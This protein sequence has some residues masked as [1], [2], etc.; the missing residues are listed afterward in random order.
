MGA[1]RVSIVVRDMV[2]SFWNGADRSTAGLA[3]KL[4]SL[5][6]VDNH[7]SY[8]HYISILETMTLM[9]R[10]EELRVF[11]AV[12][13]GRSFA[14][15]ARRL[16]ISPAQASKL[17]A[18]LEDRLGT[19]LLNRTTRDVS[20]TDNGR[21][22]LERGRG[23]MEEFDQMEKSV[24]ETTAPRGS[25]KVTA[26]V[27]FGMQQL[28]P[29]LLDF[30]TA[31][32]EV[33]LEVSFA[34]RIVNLVDDGF[35]VAI[36]IGVL[37]DS[38]LVARKLAEVRAITF[39]SPSYIAVHGR[40]RDPSELAN[41]ETILDINIKDPFVWAFGTGKKRIDVKVNGRLRFSHPFVCLA[42]ARAGLGIAR[43]PA[44]VATEDLRSGR[45]EALLREF[46]PD[47]VAIHAVYPH[48]RHLASK[49]R[50]FV[51]FMAKRFAGEPEWHQGWE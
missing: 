9:D 26:P 50:A 13:D 41:R 5:L 28:G 12:A 6:F 3:P 43:A 14:Q 47:P 31:Y 40:P 17:V 46:E 48:T 11:I 2:L 49:V 23:V 25:L 38:S 27:T 51:D 16:N 21:A 36:R 39:T 32:P 44:F 19:R 4:P 10:I 42:A 34:D 35:D 1:T 24:Q 33:G 29:A 22:Y 37:A 7:L 30:A 45:V 20:L 8:C 18:K 15:A